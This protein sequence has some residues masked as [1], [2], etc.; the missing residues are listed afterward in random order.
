M[1]LLLRFQPAAASFWPSLY[2]V[3][4]A[5]TVAL[6]LSASS[7]ASLNNTLLIYSNI[8]LLLKLSVL[9]VLWMLNKRTLAYIFAGVG[10]VWSLLFSDLIPHDDLSMV[11]VLTLLAASLLLELGKLYK[12]DAYY[13]NKTRLDIAGLAFYIGLIFI[14]V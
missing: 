5:L 2:F 4:I 3:L 6:G 13:G 10:I 9:V 8:I 14:L 12:L 11:M 7:Q 1:Y